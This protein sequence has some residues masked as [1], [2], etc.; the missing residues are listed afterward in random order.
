MA[1]VIKPDEDWVEHLREAVP[2]KAEREQMSRV[3]ERAKELRK[4]TNIAP[5]TTGDLVRAVR[6]EADQRLDNS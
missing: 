1:R 2:T 6:D 3:L 4:H 5:L